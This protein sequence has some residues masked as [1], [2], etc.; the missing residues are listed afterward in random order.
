MVD[1]DRGAEAARD[2]VAA[3]LDA[4]TRIDLQVVVVARPDETREAARDKATEAA[5]ARRPRRPALRGDGRGAWRRSADVRAGG[6]QWDLGCHGH[7]RLGRTCRSTASRLPRRSRRPR[8]RK[9]SRIWSTR[10]RSRSC[11]P[12]RRRSRASKGLPSPGSL[13]EI[14]APPTDVRDRTSA[15][16]IA[17]MIAAI[18]VGTVI[19][20]VVTGGIVAL[21]AVAVIVGLIRRQARSRLV[22]VAAG[23]S[24]TG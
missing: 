12:P 9:S 22:T 19:F 4:L 18:V 3:L 14:A 17:V 1:D 2:R 15:V 7:G 10:R 8:W 16:V 5:I 24:R 20:G 13:A 11:V 23:P 21:F 6:L